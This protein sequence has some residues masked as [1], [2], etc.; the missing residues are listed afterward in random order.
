[1]TQ[2][3][4]ADPDLAESFATQ[5]VRLRGIAYRMLGS[6]WDAEDAVQEAWLRLQRADRAGIDNLE[7]WL[8]VVI[9]RVSVDLMRARGARREDLDAELPEAGPEPADPMADVARGEELGAAMVIIL[10]ALGPL[11]R[12]AFVLHDVF[13]MPFDDVAPI[14]ERTPAAARQLASRARR[15]LRQVDLAA[16]RAKGREAVDAFIQAARAGDF[17]KLLQLLDP[18]VELRSDDAVIATAAPYADQGAPLL[19]DRVHG[20]DAVARVFAG[21]ADLAEPALV[22]GI[23]AVV[24]APEGIPAAIYSLQLRNGRITRIEAIARDSQLSDLVIVLS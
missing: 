10:D 4:A 21:R 1:M 3:P 24:Y 16:E 13:G 23:P 11:E 6:H 14:I 22:N 17:G 2:V 9:S 15:R 20:A 19:R 18:E 7:A 5:R 8:T 12:L